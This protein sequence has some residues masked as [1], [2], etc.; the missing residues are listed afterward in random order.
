MAA[1]LLGALSSALHA[2]SDQEKARAELQALKQE[3]QRISR[4]IAAASSRRE[5]L[6]EQLREAEV[7]VGRLKR[8]LAENR[9]ASTA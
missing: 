9:R 8:E 7:E 4:D 2:Q 3:M 1:L 6:Q 5:S